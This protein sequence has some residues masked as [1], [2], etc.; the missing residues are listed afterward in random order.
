MTWVD[1]SS[2]FSYGSKLT[3]TQM[4]QLRD[5][6]TALANGD[7]GAPEIQTAA[8]NNSAVTTAKIN[9]D[10]I[11][12][13]KINDGAVD[14]AELASAA[15]TTVKLDDLA[16][17]AAKLDDNAVTTDKINNSAVTTIKINDAA[18]T[19]DKINS[20]AVTEAKLGL[21]SVSKERLKSSDSGDSDFDIGTG[22]DAYS[23]VNVEMQD[24]TFFPMTYAS[25]AAIR[26]MTRYA[27]VAPTS[28][29]M[30]A[31][32]GVKN[33]G[34]SSCHVT[35][36]WRYITATDKPFMYTSCNSDGYIDGLWMCDDP[37]AGYWGMPEKPDNFTPPIARY[38]EDGRIL[39]PYKEVVVFNYPMEEFVD[40]KIRG[41]VDKKR[42]RELLN[43]QYEFDADKNKYKRKNLPQI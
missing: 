36:R 39:K 6:I 40:L 35:I 2:A 20:N 42:V 9:N 10:A 31:R 19:T 41:A 5:N 12:N 29:D 15:V 23:R 16:V 32:L 8:L 1:L 7:S 38:Q 14:T 18:V 34:A 33:T 27:G 21:A 4:Q 24:Y 26:L 11:T 13:E 28:G 30:T 22:D 37:P 25:G 43:E 17:T 3:S